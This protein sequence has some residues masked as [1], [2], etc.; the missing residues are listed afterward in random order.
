[1]RLV[2]NVAISTLN[3]AFV[4]T[5]QQ[6]KEIGGEERERERESDGGVV[7]WRN[8]EGEKIKKHEMKSQQDFSN[9]STSSFWFSVFP[10]PPKR[11]TSFS[12]FLSRPNLE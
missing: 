10:I 3:Y 12:L 7:V 9:S 6:T 4:M 1:M 11:H 2:E 8:G 5:S